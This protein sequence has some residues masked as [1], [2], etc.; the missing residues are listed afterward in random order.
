MTIQTRAR[1]RM[2]VS[3][4]P[5]PGPRQKADGSLW[6]VEETGIIRQKFLE[7]DYLA[8]AE[9]LTPLLPPGFSLRGEPVV[10]VA[11]GFFLDLWWLAGRGYGILHVTIPV[12]YRGKTET[13]DGDYMAV[14]WEG[15]GDAVLTGRDELG[16]PKLAAD[17]SDLTFDPASGSAR[18]AVSWLGH[19][20]FTAQADGLKEVPNATPPKRVPN[21]TFK[22]V[23]NT[24]VYGTGG[25]DIASVTTGA[26][27]VP[28]EGGSLA[29]QNYRRWE[30]RGEL[31]WN[32]ATFEQL[33]TTYH[34][35]NGLAAIDIVE[36]RGASYFDLNLPGIVVAG[37]ADQRTI[38]P[39]EDNRFAY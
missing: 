20:F 18:S 17:F 1:Y 5:A 21:L 22:Y 3:F 12:T 27:Q 9:Q 30:G 26:G 6:T 11:T 16:F 23:P 34:I 31:S 28:V 29:V 35:V 15:L 4:G 13:F 36:F 37:A 8:K 38:E 19:E 14:I 2:P 24:S 7:I 25:A 39:A 33:P 32:R 10:K